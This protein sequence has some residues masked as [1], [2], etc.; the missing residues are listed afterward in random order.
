MNDEQKP[1][2][3]LFPPES[4]TDRHSASADRVPIEDRQ[5]FYLPVHGFIW[6]YPE[7]VQIV[8]HPAFQRLRGVYQLGQA[9]LVYPGATHRRF[10]HCLGAVHVVHRMIN[11]VM[12]N[13]SKPNRGSQGF[14]RQQFLPG[15]HLSDEEVRFTRLGAL[16]HDIGHVPCGHTVEDELQ[17]MDRHDE[18]SRL[19]LVFGIRTL[20]PENEKQKQGPTLQELVDRLY[21]GYVPNSLRGQVSPS[22]LLRL[23][24][25]KRPEQNEEKQDSYSEK[26]GVCCS[27]NEFRL[28][29][30]RDMIGNTICADILDYLYRDWYHVG[31]PR[32][33][34]ER[35]LQYMQIRTPRGPNSVSDKPAPTS[36]D[37][38]VVSLGDRPKIRTDAVSEILGLLE[39][40]Y[41]LAE[42]VLFHRTKLTASAM[43]ERALYELWGDNK[44]NQ[45]ERDFL[46]QADETLLP[47]CHGRAKEAGKSADGKVK[48]GGQ[49]AE[50]LLVDLM[51]RKI[52]VELDTCFHEEKPG[53]F[54]KR[55]ENL[56]GRGKE[57]A[58]NRWRALRGLEE[59]FQ[60]KR[61]SL[62]MYCPTRDM[63][64]KIPEVKI[65]CNGD[66]QPFNKYE[67]ENDNILSGGHLHAQEMRFHRLWRIHF[68]ISEEERERV[69]GLGL[70]VRL[71]DACRCCV[72][73]DLPSGVNPLEMVRDLAL[74]LSRGGMPHE[75]KD[76]LPMAVLGGRTN[77]L[78][79]ESYPTGIPS[80]RSLLEKK[81]A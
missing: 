14:D 55:V 57:A 19:D 13:A 73:G 27:C 79:G 10:E 1:Q 16:L 51:E 59:D 31:K 24:I 7:E 18:D 9:H 42:S 34:D 28:T 74:A 60:L 26:D 39:W 40:R 22:E 20:V 72:L 68:F 3:P 12:R 25:R 21:A 65:Y 50:G 56:Y 46:R 64:A 58:R 6:L 61:G 66:V 78:E 29:V 53:D 15:A 52:F 43:L 44:S 81:S 80:I 47:W 54:S 11:A 36:R 38:F 45:L 30:C 4:S 67:Q 62:A 41:Q 33:V 48:A 77:P 32:P 5:E 23:L 8:D 2:P 35:L 37:M 69:K 49:T 63:N 17:L 71:I 70:L 76:V 75:G